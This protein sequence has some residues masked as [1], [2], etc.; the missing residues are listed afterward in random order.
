[1]DIQKHAR[2]IVYRQGGIAKSADFVAEGIS[3]VKV[4]ALCDEGL[5]KRVKIGRAHV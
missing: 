3:A 1:M 5:L 2:D 4:V